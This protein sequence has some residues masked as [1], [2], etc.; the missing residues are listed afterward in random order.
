MREIADKVGALYLVDMAHFAGLVAGGAHP[1]PVP[2]AHMVTT[3]THKTLRGPRSGMILCKAD[4]A[5]AVDKA[6]FRDARADRWFTSWRRR[7]L[8][9]RGVAASFKD[10]AKQVVANAKTLAKTMQDEG[11]RIISGGTDTHL[12]LVDVFSPR[13]CWAAKPRRRWAKR[14]SP[15]I[16]IDPVRHESADEAE[17]HPV[18][19]SGAYDTRHERNRNAAGRKMDRERIARADESRHAEANT[20]AGIRNGRDVPALQGTPYGQNG[21]RHELTIR[22]V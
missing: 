21:R 6:C 4:Y 3:T 15:S 17:R 16:R 10:Y 13:A 18:G 22:I 1:S 5:A 9:P 7:P 14:A 19:D 12:M 8:F 2:H 11:F 20:A